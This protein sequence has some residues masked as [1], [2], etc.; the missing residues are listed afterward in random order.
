MKYPNKIVI[1]QKAK[2]SQAP[3][4]MLLEE[5]LISKCA[6]NKACDLLGHKTI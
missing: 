1:I 4:V 5:N 3:C 6:Q 2:F